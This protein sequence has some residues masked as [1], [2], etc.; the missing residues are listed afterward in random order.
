MPEVIVLLDLN[1]VTVLGFECKINLQTVESIRKG[2]Q[3]GDNIPAVPVQQVGENTY[4]IDARPR[5]GTDNKLEGG[6]SR[7][8]AHLAECAPLKARITGTA[9][10]GMYSGMRLPLTDAELVD[11]P[12]EFELRRERRGFYR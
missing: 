7:T 10:L 9:Q 4:L 8:Y 6:H 2:I 3:N 12:E 5:N 1:K 11:D